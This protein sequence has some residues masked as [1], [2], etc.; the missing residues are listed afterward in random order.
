MPISATTRAAMLDLMFM[1]TAWA[2]MAQNNATTPNTN[3]GFSLM[4]ADPGSAGTMSTNEANYTGYTRMNVIRTGAGFVRSTNSISPIADISFPVGTGG[5]GTL[6]HFACGDPAAGA[7]PYLF[8]GT[9]T[10]TVPSGAGI[11]P[12]LL[13]T[14]TITLT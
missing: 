9:L 10:P 12:I 5:S 14:T 13:N 6:T 7:Q 1:A 3:I 4:T 8:S 2:K 11:R